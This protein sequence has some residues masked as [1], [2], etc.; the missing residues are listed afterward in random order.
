MFFAA[1]GKKKPKEKERIAAVLAG[2]MGDPAWNNTP[3]AFDFFDGKGIV[4][5]LLHELA[6]PKVRFKALFAEE[7]PHLQPGRA[8]QVL[9]GGT[10]LGW[11]G[12]IHPLAA[13]AFEA[14]A[15]VVA[16]ELDFDAL[17]KTSQPARDYVD[18]PLFPAVTMDIALV[19]DEDVTNEKLMQVM[20]SAGGK[21]L[22]SIQLFDVYRDEERL[23]AGKKSMAYALEY[24]SPDKT[25]TAEEVNK[26]HERLIK[27]TCGATGAEVRG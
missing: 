25:L 5:S 22:S 24:R 16:F 8:A 9:S 15:P 14:T 20:R 12:E 2:A 7:A 21:L 23:G 17:V 3:A 27:K 6:T 11:V 26:Q 1:E 10:V 4:E 13:D 19:V 18:V